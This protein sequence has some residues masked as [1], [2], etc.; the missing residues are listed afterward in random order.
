MSVI[1][2]EDFTAQDN[3][4]LQITEHDVGDEFINDG[5]H[6]HFKSQ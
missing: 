1:R 5:H 6:S 2:S 4:P 3:S